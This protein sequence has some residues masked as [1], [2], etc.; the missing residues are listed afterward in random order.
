MRNVVL[1]LVRKILQT[2][3]IEKSYSEAYYFSITKFLYWKFYK[4]PSHISKETF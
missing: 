1:D 2:Y 3:Y 4:I